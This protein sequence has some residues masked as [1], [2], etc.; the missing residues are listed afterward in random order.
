M[1]ALGVVA[2]SAM[3]LADGGL[4]GNV[5]DTPD[6][7]RAAAELPL[8]RLHLSG[9]D[10]AH[11]ERL[12]A[13][14]EDPERNVQRYQAENTWR[15]AQLAY[16]GRLYH[17]RVRSHGRSPS[18]HSDVI[19]GW[20]YRFISLSIKLEAGEWIHGLNRFRLIVPRALPRTEPIMSMAKLVGV[21]VQ[22]HRLVKVQINNWPGA[23]LLFLERRRSPVSGTLRLRAVSKD[24]L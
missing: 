1:A 16:D 2:V 7:A 18:N 14:L 6:G 15:R 10:V 20:R 4:F 17:I 13:H 12:Y 24:L 23:P 8:L 3:A 22:D 21:F 9:A 5:P 19:A 11:F